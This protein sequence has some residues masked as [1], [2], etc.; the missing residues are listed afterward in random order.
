ME[1]ERRF[2]EMGQAEGTRAAFLEFLADDSIVFEPS[3]VDG[4]KNWGARPEGGLWLT[5]QPVFAAMS[6][7]A[8]LGY[9]TGP[10]EWRKNKEDEKP[11][12]YGQYIS[13]WKKQKDGTWKVALDVGHGNPRPPNPPGEPELSFPPR[14][15][16]DMQTDTA[17][18]KRKLAEA[19]KKFAATAKTDST[20]AIAEAARD[21]VRVHRE[22]MFPGLGKD[23]VGLMLSVRRGKLSL[24][25]AGE[26]MS[27]AGDLAYVYGKYLLARTQSDERGHYLQI[28]RADADGKW[29]LAL[30]FQVPLPPEQK[31]PAS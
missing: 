25:Q 15:G 2:Y 30:D 3:P 26:A 31:K 22:G 29:K 24:T 13:I 1:G 28:W 5:W 12:G 18:A 17:V 20:A 8:D 7:S 23:A 16:A 9:T 21:D 10:S 27:A 19:K 14:Q 4:K 11:A 6:A